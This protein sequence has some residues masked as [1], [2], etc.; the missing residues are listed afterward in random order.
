MVIPLAVGEEDGGNTGWR[1]QDDFYVLS[2]AFFELEGNDG[3]GVLQIG[4]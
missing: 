2:F 3:L 4:Y 1:L